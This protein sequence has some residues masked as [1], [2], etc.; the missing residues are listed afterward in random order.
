M[1]SQALRRARSI[2]G[3]FA[4]FQFI[5]QANLREKRIASASAPM[6]QPSEVEIVISQKK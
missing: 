3:K 2:D 6:A 1:E 4:G 5:G